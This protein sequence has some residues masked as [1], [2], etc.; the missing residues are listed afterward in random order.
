MLG[1]QTPRMESARPH[2]APRHQTAP[3]LV[4]NETPAQTSNGKHAE[5]ETPCVCRE[6]IG[7]A[8]F[9][10]ALG[11]MARERY[12]ATVALDLILK[13]PAKEAKRPLTF[14]QAEAEAL[15]LRT[16]RM[17]RTSIATGEPARK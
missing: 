16:H 7:R 9:F 17:W 3:A 14:T 13:G 11:L 5:S 1:R 6:G 10:T 12:T 8:R 4:H 2:R 15:A